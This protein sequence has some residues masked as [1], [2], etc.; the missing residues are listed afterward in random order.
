[1]ENHCQGPET[2]YR[3]LFQGPLQIA[4]YC[5]GIAN[6][7]ILQRLKAVCFENM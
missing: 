7:I 3:S 2:G 4:R 6:A 1:M 5:V